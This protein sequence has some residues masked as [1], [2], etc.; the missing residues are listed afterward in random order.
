MEAHERLTSANPGPLKVRFVRPPHHYP[1][2]YLVQTALGR[3]LQ[4]DHDRQTWNAYAMTNYADAR[5]ALQKIFRQLER[6][7][8]SAARSVAAIN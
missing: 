7:N 5:E 2:S 3:R 6:I 1:Y 4:K 8:P